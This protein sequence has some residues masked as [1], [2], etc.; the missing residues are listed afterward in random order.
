M[1]APFSRCPKH[2]H[3][4]YALLGVFGLT[5]FFTGMDRWRHSSGG[6]AWM[7]ALPLFME[8]GLILCC[9]IYQWKQD[10]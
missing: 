3:W 1:S 2:K 5:L 4:M 9:C 7:T 8:A 10:K 6:N